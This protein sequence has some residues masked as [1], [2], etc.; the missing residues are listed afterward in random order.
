MGDL[1]P[2]PVLN[3]RKR[4]FVIPTAL[5]LRGPLKPLVERLLAPDRLAAQG[6]FRRYIAQT[7][8]ASH[9]SGQADRSA[10]IWTL[11]MFQLWHIVF[12]EHPSAN[13]PAASWRDLC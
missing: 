5:W 8:V 11:L 4:G 2:P 12:V 10:Q 13:P 9:L 6:L 3:G 1:L 7:I